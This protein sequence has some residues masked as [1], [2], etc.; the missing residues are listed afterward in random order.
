MKNNFSETT[1]KL[2]SKINDGY[3]MIPGCVNQ[4]VDFHHRFPNTLY[5]NKR[6]PLFTQSIF[7]IANLCREHHDNFGC[8]EWLKITEQ[9]AE[10]YNTWL[11]NFKED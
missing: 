3:C 5:N 6:Y 4:S 10:M 7:N 11:D 2:A 1:R 8:F 9:Q